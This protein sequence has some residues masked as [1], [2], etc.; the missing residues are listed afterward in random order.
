[1]R[2]TSRNSK[3]YNVKRKCSERWQAKQRAL[4]MVPKHMWI[5]AVHERAITETIERIT[6][7]YRSTDAYKEKLSLYEEEQSARE[8]REQERE[9]LL[10]EIL[11]R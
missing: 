1:M 11:P 6:E 3:R 5:P 2:E 10:R 8:Q 7:A 4:G 9:R